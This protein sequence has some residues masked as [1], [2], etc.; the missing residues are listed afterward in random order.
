MTLS[1]SE[2]KNLI[3]VLA[4][5]FL[6]LGFFLDILPLIIAIICWIIILLLDK[7]FNKI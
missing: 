1:K 3:Y 6:I 7:Y 2:C 4:I 5:L